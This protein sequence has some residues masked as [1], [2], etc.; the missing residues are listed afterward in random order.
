MATYSQMLK[1]AMTKGN[2]KDASDWFLNTFQELSTLDTR[3]LIQKGEASRLTKT[4]TIGRMYLFHYDPKWKDVLPLYDR[5]PLIFP[6]DHAEGGFYGINFHYLPYMQR[7]RLLDSL[8]DLANN[9]SFND[10]MRLNLSYRLLKSVAKS[11]YYEPCVKRYLNSH[12]R[13]RFLLVSPQEWN[14]AL[15]LPLEDFVY[16]KK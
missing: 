3:A 10:K 12:V 9:N 13:S 2:I 8:M 16:K 6:F 4:I 14:K 1:Q 11:K 5:F 15:V 7:A